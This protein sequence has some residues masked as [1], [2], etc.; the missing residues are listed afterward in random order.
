MSNWEFLFVWPISQGIL[1]TPNK[2]LNAVKKKKKEE[3]EEDFKISRKDPNFNINVYPP[4][5][6]PFHYRTEIYMKIWIYITVDGWID[7]QI[8]TWIRT[9]I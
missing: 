6:A 3:E 4:T 7:R 9:H 5:Q 1:E 2:L 8:E